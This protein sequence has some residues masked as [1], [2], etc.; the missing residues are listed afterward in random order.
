MIQ[1]RDLQKTYRLGFFR[2]RVDALRGATFEVREGDLFG[3]IGPNGAG[4]ST[5]IKI[6]LGLLKADSGDAVLMGEK[7]GTVSS[8]KHVGFLPEQ[9]YFYDYLTAYEFLQFYGGLA[10]LRGA[11]LKKTIDDIAASTGMKD[12]WMDRKLRTFS[13]GMLQRT[14]L[15]QALLSRP[16]LVILDEPMSGLDPMGRK[17][18]RE[19]LKNLHRQ[20]VTV[21]YSSHVL[22]DVEA[23]CTRLAMMVAGQVRRSGT[24]DEVLADEGKA[25]GLI[26]S[27]PYQPDVSA[28]PPEALDRCVWESDRSL[29]CRD[30]S[31]RDLA[32]NWIL[33]QGLAIESL[34]RRRPSLEDV[35]AQE[36][37]RKS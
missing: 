28:L 26:L 29:L 27:Q 3:F 30:E 17:D 25:Y 24:V 13:K 18:V 4:K 6:L 8:R 20:G 11:E 33:S 16:R 36:V 1:V 19:L 15:A 12:E 21:F 23:I 7:A 9:P 2:K 35:L 5:S 10:G 34:E 31:A 32:L 14:G 22:A 37:L